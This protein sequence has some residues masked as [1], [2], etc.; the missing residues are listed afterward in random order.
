MVILRKK[1]E[2]KKHKIPLNY[3]IRKLL[4][5]LE[6]LC[7]KERGEGPH[8]LVG[9]RM[10]TSASLMMNRLTSPVLKSP[11]SEHF[12]LSS[13]SSEPFFKQCLVAPDIS[14]SRL[15]LKYKKCNYGSSASSVVCKVSV[16]PQTE[17][18]GLNIAEDVTQVG[19]SHSFV[20]ILNL[21]V[22]LWRI[23]EF[24]FVS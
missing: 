4:S 10:A 14:T 18:E 16:K 2:K 15:S 12:L 3:I 7:L 19:F 5:F 17:V 8:L 9:A 21:S 11:K 6:E 24:L 23:L 20:R 13:F 1:P 22:S